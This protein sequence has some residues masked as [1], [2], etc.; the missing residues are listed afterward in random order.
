MVEPAAHNRL[1]VGSNPAGCT[2]TARPDKR[3]G[4]ISG[5]NSKHG[6]LSHPRRV[7]Y[8]GVG[9]GTREALIKPLAADYRS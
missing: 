2:K 5:K 4:A 3:E 7:F 9:V 6:S 1:V 8:F